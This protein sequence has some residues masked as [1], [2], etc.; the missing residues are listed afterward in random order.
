MIAIQD[1]YDR[2][3]RQLN[4]HLKWSGFDVAPF[5]RDALPLEKLLQ[6]YAFY[7]VSPQHPLNYAF[8]N[9]NLAGSCFLGNCRVNNAIL[10]KSDVRGDELKRAGD[11][12][13]HDRFDIVMTRDETIDIEDSLL[14]KTLVHSFSH[15]PESL[16]RFGIANTVALAYANIHGSP[17]NGCFL[18]PFATV[19]LTTMSDCAIGT[20]SYVQAGQIDHLAIA[21]GTIWVRIPG[22]CHFFY[23]HPVAKLKRYIHLDR[24]KVPRGELIDFMNHYKPAFQ[25]I[26]D[27]VRMKPLK[28]V[29]RSASL[30]RY[31]VVRPKT[32]IGENVWVAQRA[33]LENAYLGK[34]ASAQENCYIIN[35]RLAGCNVTAH[36]AKIIEA[37]IG[38][39]SYVGFNSF[40]RGRPGS[41]LKVGR[42][43]IV[44]PHT[45]IDSDAPLRIPPGRLVWGMIQTPADLATHSISLERLA[46]VTSGIAYGATVFEGDGTAIVNALKGR[47]QRILATNGAFFDGDAHRGHAQNNQRISYNTIQPYSQGEHEG[48]FP[49]MLIQP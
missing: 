9:T 32:H 48:L 47:L 29:P 41:R 21:P 24:N 14:I 2:I 11:V 12:V 23:R 38:E 15:D 1:L 44:M 25:R 16:D 8:G 39:N 20:F 19:D 18:G 13:R 6:F 7:G 35:A 26:F 37:D 33:Y 40:L 34:G 17:S 28:G 36:G 49:R 46:R 27:V 30:D 45:I 5:I 31:A 4:I 10:Y 3:V 42:E 43:S 22:V